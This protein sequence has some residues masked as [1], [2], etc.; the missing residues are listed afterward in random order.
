MILKIYILNECFDIG[1][2]HF[3]SILFFDPE[4]VVGT[5]CFLNALHGSDLLIFRAVCIKTDEIGAVEFPFRKLLPRCFVDVDLTFLE[6]LDQVDVQMVF[7]S[8]QGKAFV[9]AE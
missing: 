7:Q 1:N 3:A 2:Q 4:V 9:G 8:D 5:G 6:L